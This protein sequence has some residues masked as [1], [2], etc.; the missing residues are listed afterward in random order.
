MIYCNNCVQYYA[1]DSDYRIINGVMYCVECAGLVEHELAEDELD[2][3]SLSLK[4]K[5][6]DYGYDQLRAMIENEDRSLES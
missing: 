5:Y 3:R 2:E 4:D 1:P 6:P